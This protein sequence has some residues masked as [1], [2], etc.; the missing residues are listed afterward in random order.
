VGLKTGFDTTIWYPDS[1][2]TSPPAALLAVMVEADATVSTKP[3]YVT[4]LSF[5]ARTSQGSTNISNKD[6]GLD[7]YIVLNPLAQEIL[8]AA[9]LL[10]FPTTYLEAD[11]HKQITR[12][13]VNT[14]GEG[15]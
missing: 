9:M 1:D 8:E 13:K 7:T 15:S 14:T 2:C 11:S 3:G 12:V 6:N 4:M 5:D 10:N